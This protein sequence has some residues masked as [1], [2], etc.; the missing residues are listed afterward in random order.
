MDYILND[1]SHL[2]PGHLESA[3]RTFAGDEEFYAMLRGDMGRGQRV[4]KKSKRQL[5]MEREA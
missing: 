5:Q 3:L 4:K 2:E 1:N